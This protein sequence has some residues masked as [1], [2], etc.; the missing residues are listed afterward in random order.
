VYY[1]PLC[2]VCYQFDNLQKEQF[3]KDGQ[4]K[5]IREKFSRAQSELSRLKQEALKNIERRMEEKSRRELDLEQ[6]TERLKTD[7]QFK[8]RELAELRGTYDSKC[9]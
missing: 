2:S 3:A 4:I 6:D 1:C 5:I 8:E 7:L 9:Q